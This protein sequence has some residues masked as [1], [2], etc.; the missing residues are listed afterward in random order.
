MK[1]IIHL[2]TGLGRGGAEN[3]LYRVLTRSKKFEHKVFSL[4]GDDAIGEKLISN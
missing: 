3:A 2:I 4:A 1:K